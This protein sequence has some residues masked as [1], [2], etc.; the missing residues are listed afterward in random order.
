MILPAS[1]QPLRLQT[2]L[3]APPKTTKASTG[4][5]PPI[6]AVFGFGVWVL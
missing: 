6:E 4:V 5:L 3:L 2:S 1:V